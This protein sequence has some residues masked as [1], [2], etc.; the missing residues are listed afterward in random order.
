MRVRAVL[1][2]GL[3]LVAGAVG[4]VL[5]GSP[6][7][8][9]RTNSALLHAVLGSAHGGMTICQAGEAPPSGTS[10]V[11]LSLSAGIGPRVE[12]V[13]LSGRHVLTRGTRGAGWTGSD[14][15]VPVR[16]I[17]HTDAPATVCFALGESR[18]AM[19]MFGEPSAPS[20]A[21]SS[22][23][24]PFPGRLRIE[25]LGAGTR[26]WWSSALSVARRIGL[27]RAPSGTWVALLVASLMTVVVALASFLSVRDLE[28]RTRAGSRSA[29]E[30]ARPSRA[31]RRVPSAAWICAAVAILNATCWSLLSPPFQVPDEPSH[32]AYVQQLAEAHRLPTGAT[33]EFSPEETTALED[34]HHGAVQFRPGLGT[35][36]T[37]TQ[38]R[39]LEHDLEQPLP[40]RGP[41]DA[42]DAANEPPLYYALE[43]VPYELGSSGTLLDQLELMRLFSA[44]LGGVTAFFAFLFVREALPG[45]PWAWTVAGLGVALSPL[46]GFISGAVNPEAMLCAVSAALFYLLARA[47][48]RGLTQRLAV[49]IGASIAIGFLTKLNFLGLVPGTIVALIVVAAR[50]PASSRR[51]AYTALAVALLVASSPALLYVASRSLVNHQSLSAASSYA[52]TATRSGSMLSEIS[53]IWQFYLPRL[54]GTTNYFPGILTT[55]QL[56]FDGLIGLYGWADTVFPGW[57]YDAALVPA[58]LVALLCMRALLACRLTAS[59]RVLELLLYTAMAAGLMGLVGTTS[60]ISD[61]L[62][63]EGAFWEPRY[64]LPLIPLLGAALAVAARGSGRRW[65]A[66]VGVLI[67]VLVLAHDI[68]SQLLVISRYYS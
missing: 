8:I 36:S 33:L 43:T 61:A 10:A 39:Q 20:T 22:E 63:N 35:I 24:E 14:V 15:T 42:G 37:R 49:A 23:G 38:E 34:L 58:C 5:S 19:S 59:K 41:G 18:E 53:Y 47:F 12:L 1:A 40:T 50:G 67:V 44:L 31:L 28:V 45:R 9:L 2:I 52:S 27:G 48:R 3:V 46:L 6:V 13:L 30:R 11:R 4:L 51:A 68:F 26:S 60:Y 64:L 21:A 54:P 29:G 62:Q 56:W 65:G 16:P 17:D 55:R 57:V 32:F 66:T 25:Y 7:R